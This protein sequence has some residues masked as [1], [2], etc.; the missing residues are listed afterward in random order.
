MTGR[1]AMTTAV[2]NRSGHCRRRWLPRVPGARSRVEGRD[3][4]AS[5][6]WPGLAAGRFGV[7]SAGML[8]RPVLPDRDAGRDELSERSLRV[9]GR[10]GTVAPSGARVLPATSCINP[11]TSILRMPGAPVESFQATCPTPGLAPIGGQF[12]ALNNTSE[13]VSDR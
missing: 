11:A 2:R 5:R 4:A 9:D 7:Q 6:T 10:I 13:K 3:P 12:S 8:R 1:F